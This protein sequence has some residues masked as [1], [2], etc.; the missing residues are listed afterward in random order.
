MGEDLDR[1][2]GLTGPAQQAEL[3]ALLA[4][5]LKPGIQDRAFFHERRLRPSLLALADGP[6]A[7][8]A[9][10]GIL[11]FIGVPSDLGWLV[12]HPPP[13]SRR[14]FAN[15]WAYAIATALLEPSD[16]EQWAFLRKCAFDEYND[17]WVNFGAITTLK[18]IASPQSVAILEQAR[19]KNKDRAE[20]IDRALEWIRSKPPALAHPDLD[21]AARRVARAIRLGN[22]EGN[23]RPRYNEDG[24]MALVDSVFLD[25]LDRLTYT[26]TF[27]KVDGVGKLRG[28]RETMQALSPPPPPPNPPAKPGPPQT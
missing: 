22:W 6:Y 4:S 13:T 1:I 24:D 16:E 14:A 28:V 26:A 9:A 23:G 8:E 21:E 27:H 3:R 19:A 15:R 10:R 2:A 25:G 7:G 12:H 18:L 20:Q 17:G 11:A 5:D